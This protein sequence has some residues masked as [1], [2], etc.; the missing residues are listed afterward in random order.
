MLNDNPM[1]QNN[2]N[3]ILM[4]LFLFVIPT[5][6]IKSTLPQTP[7]EAYENTISLSCSPASGGMGTEVTVWIS[8]TENQNE[9][10][11]FGFEMTFDAAVFQLQ[12]TG[13]GN[14]CGSWVTVDANESKSGKLIVGGY[15]GSGNSIASGNS[16][17]LAQ[18]KFKV[19]YAGSDDGFTR[20]FTIK[21][22]TDNISGMKPDPASTTF[23]FRK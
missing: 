12:K 18:I 22:Y 10:S 23:T 19:I 6:K 11:A 5:C 8:I 17:S 2:I 1:A 9:I 13:K 21:N 4:I 15:M 16:G 14:L 3:I 20:Q 7:D